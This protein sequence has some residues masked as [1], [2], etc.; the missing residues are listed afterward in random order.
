MKIFKNRGDIFIS[1]TSSKADKEQTVLLSVLAVI[2]LF[3]IAFVIFIGAKNDFSIKKFFEPEKTISVSSSEALQELPQVKGKNNYLFVITGKD[4]ETLYLTGI[5]QTD[6]DSVSYKVCNLLPNTSLDGNALSAIYKNGGM[7]NLMQ[8][9]EKDLSIDI[10]YYIIMNLSDFEKF[11]D[12]LG[13]VNYPLIQDIKFKNSTGKDTYS[14][15]LSAGEQILDGKKF[16]SLL[17][18]YV[19]EKKDCKLA[20]DLVLNSLNQLINAENAENKE[21]LFKEF[22]VLSKTNFTV[23]DFSERTDNITVLADSRTGVNS[24]N[25]EITYKNGALDSDSKSSVKSYFAK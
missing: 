13:S 8:A 20:N 18:Y 19:N 11:F 22:I 25:V 23:K 5:M 17:R 2:L 12:L 16:T 6:M 10:D 7:N 14:L 9:V 4:E 1:K 24:Y 3:S 21:T 15:K